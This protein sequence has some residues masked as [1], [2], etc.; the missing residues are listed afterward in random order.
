MTSRSRPCQFFYRKFGRGLD[1]SWLTTI[2][3]D[4][5][6]GDKV[7]E[8]ILPEMVKLCRKA[9]IPLVANICQSSNPEDWVYLSRK[10][11]EA[12]ADAL[13]LNFGCPQ[14]EFVKGKI[15]VGVTLGEKL[16]LSSEIVRLV[17]KEVGCPVWVKSSAIYSPPE[18]HVLAWKDAGA[19]AFSAHAPPLGMVVDVDR[20]EPFGAPFIVGYMPG[21]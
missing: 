1:Y 15:P 18:T 11:D 2:R 13:E 3:L 12:G 4:T 10:L 14:T 17:K 16:E 8:K 9:E 5:V 6:M 20:E 21:R 19:D 7:A